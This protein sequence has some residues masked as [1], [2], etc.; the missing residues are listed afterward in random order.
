MIDWIKKCK[1]HS[2]ESVAGNLGLQQKGG[3]WSPCPSCGA[4]QSGKQDKRFPLGRVRG[5]NNPTG[6]RCFAC[7]VGGDLMDLVSFRIEGCKC[8]DV[9]DYSG[10]KEFFDVKEFSTMEVTQSEKEYPPTKDLKELWGATKEQP[11]SSFQHKHIYTFLKNRSI[12]PTTIDF[13]YVFPQGFNYVSLTKVE[14]SNGKMM[15]WWTYKWASTYPLMIPLWDYTGTMRSFQGRSLGGGKI[16]GP[17]T[18]CPVGFSM[19]GLVFACHK[20]LDFMRKVETLPV[21][22]FWIVE[23]EMDFLCLKSVTKD[24]VIGVKNGSMKFF[25]HFKFPE[26]SEVVIAT[27][28]DTKGDMY[29]KKI[30]QEIYPATLYRLVLDGH[31]DLNE[32]FMDGWNLRQVEERITKMDTRELA[33]ELGLRIL[34]R[35]YTEVE[36]ATR[37]DRVKTVATLFD[38]II[39]ITEAFKYENE[40]ATKT[41]YKIQSL[42]GCSSICK[43]FRGAIQIRLQNQPTMIDSEIEGPDT[44]VE[45]VRKPIVEKGIVIGYG[46]IKTIEKNIVAI[47]RDDRRMKGRFKLNTHSGMVQVDG[48]DITDNKVLEISLWIQ[49]QYESFR[50]DTTQIGRCIDY[51]ASL[52]T[53]QFHPVQELLKRIH[54]ETD[55]ND[56]P[57]HARPELLF[58][59]YFG[60]KDSELVQQYSKR[61]MISA[62][63]RVME[64]GCKSDALPVLIGPQGCGKSTGIRKLALE[65]RFFADTPFDVKNKDAY[66]MLRGVWLYEIGEA[67]S[68]LQGGFRAIKGFITSQVDRFRKPYRAHVTPSPRG[69]VFLCTTNEMQLEFLSDPTGSRRYWSMMVGVESDVLFDEIEADNVYLWKRA[70]DMYY[71]TGEYLKDG[72]DQQNWLPREFEAECRRQNEKFG[73]SD[74]WVPFIGNYVRKRWKKW[75]AERK[76]TGAKNE[77]ML[78]LQINEILSDALSIPANKQGRPEEKRCGEVLNQIGV[79]PFA[80]VRIGK[81]RIRTWK[82]PEDFDDLEKYTLAQLLSR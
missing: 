15:P 12:D 44:S 71:G 80:Q 46:S 64:P 67:E 75:A 42:Y 43:K 66:Q 81:R 9:S 4:T 10:I 39:P 60:A 33:A 76:K 58:S 48:E 27:D 59:H 7:G 2:F 65:D 77:D 35:K 55:L 73:T 21:S 82:I 61:F 24:P 29:A 38:H 56:A 18:M 79:H 3:R 8:S 68:L 16:S 32:A 36:N 11:V 28:N 69:N 45:L 14:T 78:L 49:E 25:R 19:T 6:W 52:P 37:V 34:S 26:D 70:M 72:P 17:K 41:F 31:T 47:I 13:G 74:P 63:K 50:M 20:M 30:A 53:N 22:K 23:G 40:K 51:V 57:D 54:A 5:T 62:I 1:Q